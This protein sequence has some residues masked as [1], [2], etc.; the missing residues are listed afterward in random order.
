MR[1][2]SITIC[3]FVGCIAL[4]SVSCWTPP[5]K[6]WK[7]G[8]GYRDAKPIIAALEKFH[9]DRGQ[10]PADLQE[11]VPIY[12]EHPPYRR[13]GYHC[14]GDRFGLQFSYTG[15]GMNHCCTIPK[16]KS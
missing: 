12:L 13:F 7:A 4:S 10:Y 15:P 9:A 8:A 5:G 11:L 14:E 16:R 6:G 2:S 3:F 1:A